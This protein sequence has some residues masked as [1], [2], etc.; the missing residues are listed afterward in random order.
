MKNNIKKAPVKFRDDLLYFQ[1]LC[2][3]LSLPQ[4]SDYHHLKLA[5]YKFRLMLECVFQLISSSVIWNVKFLYKLQSILRWL[6]FNSQTANFWY[7]HYFNNG[8]ITA[9]RLVASKIK[10]EGN[11]FRGSDFCYFHVCL[12]PQRSTLK[13]K[14]SSR[15]ESFPFK[16]DLLIRVLGFG[17]PKR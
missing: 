15:S 1:H 8:T 11:Y 9:A 6:N 7:H 13:G 14:K 5:Q 10:V 3:F 12:P 17:P 16:V 4:I 2:W